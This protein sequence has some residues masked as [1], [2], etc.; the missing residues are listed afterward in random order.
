MNSEAFLRHHRLESNPFRGEE[1]RQDAED[2]RDSVAAA[3]MAELEKERRAFER[4]ADLAAADA[5]IAAIE[6]KAR[7]DRLA[8][9]AQETIFIF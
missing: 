7:A 3:K 9:A 2:R 6:A 8:A 5:K 4:E 1:A